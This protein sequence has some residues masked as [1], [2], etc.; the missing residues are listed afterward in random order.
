MVTHKTVSPYLNSPFMAVSMKGLQV[1]T[2]VFIVKKNLLPIIS[3]LSNM[4]GITN[5]TYSRYPWH[6]EYYSR[7]PRLVKKKIWE[8]SLVYLLFIFIVL[9]TCTSSTREFKN[10]LPFHLAED[11]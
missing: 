1:K 3:T 8:A 11:L 4:M 5:S 10:C 2:P 6:R 9:I 7:A